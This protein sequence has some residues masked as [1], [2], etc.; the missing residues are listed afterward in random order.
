M[1]ANS[2]E[3]IHRSN[4]VGMGVIPCQL[5]HGITAATLGLSGDEEFDLL[6]LDE[7]AK[8]RQAV[9]LV[10]KR[11]N[12]KQE[13]VELMLRLDTPAEL[14]YVRRGGILPYVL[15]GLTA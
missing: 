4:L 13:R 6:G 12:G 14:D 15:A 1:I 8:P 10:I 2:F 5:P 9:T 11:Q 7:Q 3:R